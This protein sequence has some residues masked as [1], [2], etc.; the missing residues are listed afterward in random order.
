MGTR[1]SYWSTRGSTPSASTASTREEAGQAEAVKDE[2]R[3]HNV[4][5]W[6]TPRTAGEVKDL[7]YSGYAL[8]SGQN[9]GVRSSSDSR[10]IAVPGG[11]WSHDMATVG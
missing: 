6:I 2:C 8:H 7:L 1:S 3:K 5:Q 9:F 4:G 11:R 10:G